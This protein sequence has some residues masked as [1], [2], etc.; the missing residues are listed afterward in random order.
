[1]TLQRLSVASLKEEIEVL[2]SLQVSE[3][4]PLSPKDAT[5]IYHTNADFD[6]YNE[7]K[8]TKLPGQTFVSKS[9]ITSPICCRLKIVDGKIDDRA[10]S[11][12]DQWLEWPP[13]IRLKFI[14]Y[15]LNLM[16]IMS[17]NLLS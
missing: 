17:A 13:L 6:S 15:L 1:M 10:F 3:N 8:L 12:S 7:E 9:V 14:V 5:G 16:T 11:N 2:S 4:D